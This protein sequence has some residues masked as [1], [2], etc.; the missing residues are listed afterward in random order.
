MIIGKQEKADT[1]TEASAENETLLQL[2]SLY[3]DL[4]SS[5]T[6]FEI[7]ERIYRIYTG[8]WGMFH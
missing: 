7:N 6:L 8:C 4:P 3:Y 5:D 2:L 1:G